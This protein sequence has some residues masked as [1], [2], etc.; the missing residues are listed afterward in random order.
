MCLVDLEKVFDRVPRTVMEWALRKKEIPD[1]L[2]RSVMSLYEGAKTR[3]RMDYDLSEEF[4]VQMHQGYVQSPFLS[5][6]VVD[7]VTEF[8]RE[9][10]LRELLYA[11][12]L[13]LMIETIEGLRDKFLKWKKADSVLGLQCGKWIHG[14]SAGVKRVTPK[15]SKNFTC[16]KCEGNIAEGVKQE[17]RLQ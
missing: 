12:D 8:A 1:I 2:V 15:F 17:V 9:G 6:V 5:A 7:V 11:G 14:R 16:R 13:G 10:A 4:E 3:D